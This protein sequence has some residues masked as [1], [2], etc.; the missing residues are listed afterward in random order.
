M[1][2]KSTT[3]NPPGVHHCVDAVIYEPIPYRA[4]LEVFSAF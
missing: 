4:A 3:L 1:V 2:L